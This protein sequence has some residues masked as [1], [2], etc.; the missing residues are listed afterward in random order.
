MALPSDRAQE[1]G[2]VVGAKQYVLF[3]E[4]LPSAKVNDVVVDEAGNR[5]LIRSLSGDHVTALALNAVLPRSVARY[6][7]LPQRHLFSLGDH[8]FGRIINAL[9]EPIDGGEAFPAGNTPLALD[10]DAV[11]IE[12]RVPMREQLYTGITVVDT[13]L[14]IAKGQRQLIF[15]PLRSGKTTFLTDIVLN[16]REYGVVCIYTVVGKSLGELQRISDAILRTDVQAPNIIIAALSDQPSPIVALAPA[17]AFLVA[18]HFQKRGKDVLIILD[19]LDSH[20]KYLR[21]IA[22]LE[23]RLPGRE[24]YPGDLFYQH[25]HLME[26]SGHFDKSFGGG[27][28]T[29]LPVIEADS[30]DVSDLIPTNLMSC[31]DGNFSFLAAIQAEGVYPALSEEQSVTRV[32]RHA[33]SLVQKQLSTRIR[34]HLGPYRRQ[35]AYAQF[36]TQGSEEAQRVLHQGELIYHMMRQE[37]YERIPADVQAPL[38]ALTQ[39]PFLLE[40]DVAFLTAHKKA[41]TAGILNDPAL[42][43]LRELTRKDMPLI[44]Y[45]E[46]LEAKREA[47]ESICRA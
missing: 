31:T 9:G 42:Q 10:V 39:T 7:F 1:V 40:R 14:P 19:D 35:R 37:R 4:G 20:A 11:G 44:T 43:E 21:E 18:D 41:L 6:G 15:G 24:S 13:L 30:K 17:V 25:A 32:G 29:T 12:S 8:L 5:A 2:F 34:M 26:R 45:L 33:Q 28:I 38:L 23:G 22:L 3:I 47:F 27:S 16:Q 46:H 36:G